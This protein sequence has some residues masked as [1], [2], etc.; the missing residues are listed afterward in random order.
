MSAVLKPVPPPQPPEPSLNDT[1][2]LR[3]LTCGS[4]DDGK[5]TLLGR[6]LFDSQAV[7]DDQ[8]IALDQES[9]RWGTHG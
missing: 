5:S 3:V 7:M 9:R 4:V 6:L 2:Q 8:L 1:P